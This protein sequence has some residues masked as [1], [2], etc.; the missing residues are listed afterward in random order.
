MERESAMHAV[1]NESI[2]R[3]LYKNKSH[4]GKLYQH[5][6]HK[7]KKYHKRGNEYNTRGLLKNRISIAQRPKIVKKKSRVG[8]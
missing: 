7:N 1:C 5:L 8:D 4:A 2:H 3:Y 6:R